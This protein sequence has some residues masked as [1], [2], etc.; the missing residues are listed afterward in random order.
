MGKPQAEGEPT[1]GGT[2]PLIAEE[3][4]RVII[5]AGGKEHDADG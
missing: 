3:R 4:G 2:F 5:S 1:P